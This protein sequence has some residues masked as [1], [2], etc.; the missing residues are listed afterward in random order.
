MNHQQ[1][2]HSCSPY[3]EDWN[4]HWK[5]RKNCLESGNQPKCPTSWSC[6][7][8]HRLVLL[9]IRQCRL[10]RNASFNKNQA[11]EDLQLLAQKGSIEMVKMR[12]KLGKTRGASIQEKPW[13]NYATWCCVEWKIKWGHAGLS[14]EH[15]QFEWKRRRNQETERNFVSFL[16]YL[17]QV[18]KPLL[19]SLPDSEH[20]EFETLGFKPSTFTPELRPILEDSKSTLRLPR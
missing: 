13:G 17:K 19:K 8:L 10:S 6:N 9:E 1:G 7:F 18:S 11:H 3:S 14:S 5:I 20:S 15:L 16:P 2:S 12:G 4:P